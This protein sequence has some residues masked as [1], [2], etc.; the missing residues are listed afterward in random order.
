MSDETFDGR[1][2]QLD[3]RRRLLLQRLR[4]QRRQQP[5]TIGARPAGDERVPL[6]RA[7]EQLWFLAQLAPAEPTYNLV[8][9]SYLAGELD[10]GALR[11]ALDEVVRRHEALR[12]VVETADGEAYQRVLPPG[13]VTLATGDV[14]HLPPGERRA[15]TLALLQEKEVHR[16]FDLAAGPLFRARL[17]R[18]GPTEHALALA[19]HHIVVDGWSMGLVIRELGAAYDAYRRGGRPELP[20]PPLQYP[21]FA[22]WQRRHPAPADLE[23]HLR[24]W[25]DR[26][27][28]L[29][30]LELPTDRPRPATASFTGAMLDHPL[31]PQLHA[32][33]QALAK[34]AG[35][36][37]FMV[38]VA[39]FGALLARY[40]GADDLAVGT[41]FGGRSRPEL[42]GVVG[43][44]ANMGVLRLDASGDPSFATLVDRARD[45]CLG[46]W[47][48]QDAPFERVVQRLAPPRD[49]SRNPL[50]QVAVQL[51]D[52]STWGGPA[53]PGTDSDPVD[54]R[55]DRSRFDMMVSLIDHGDRYSVL[56]EYS[57]DLFEARRVRTMLDHLARLLDAGLADPGTRL[58]RLPLLDPA[59]RERVLAVGAGE[60][61]EV[62]AAT[63]L[64]LVRAQAERTPDL[65]AVRH[66]D[67]ELTYRELLDRAVRR[68][69]G[70]RAA[71]LR[72]G[73]R[74]P[75]LLDRGVDEVLSP[76]AIWHA[77]GVY[78]PLDTA[79][80]PNRLRRILTNCAARLLLT[81]VEHAAGVPDGPWRTLLLDSGDLDSG[82]LAP[83]VTAGADGPGPDDLAYVLHTSGTTGDPKGVQLPHRGF[84]TYLDW[85]RDLWRCGPGD[86]VLHGCAPVFDLAA[87]EVLAA[88]TSGATVVVI[89]KDRLLSP[90]GLAG[91]LEQERITH[92]FLTPTT[93][94]LAE[95]DTD[96]FGALREVLVGGEVCPADLV[97]RWARPGRRRF[98]NLYGPTEA[99][100]GCLAHD[101]TDWSASTPPPIG[102]SMPNRRTYVVDRWDNPVPPGVPGEILVGGAALSTGYLNDVGL[103]ARRFT[104]DP[105]VPDG[106]VYRTGDRGHWD[107][108]GRL[109]FDGRLDGQV[110]LRGLR[111]ELDEIEATLSRH[112]AV[113]RAAVTVVRDGNGVQRL[114][115]YV[116]DAAVPA[117][118]V[119]LRTHLAAELPAHLVP[120]HLVRLP[121]L[122]LTTSGK[123]NRRML[124]APEAGDVD[125]VGSA[126][127]GTTERQVAEI[128][129]EVLGVARVGAEAS[130]FD[131]GGHSL[132]A[133][134]VL[135]RVAGRLG[136]SVPLKQFYTTPTV[137][138]VARLAGHGPVA[139]AS[140]LVSLKPGG[141]RPRLYCP[142]AVSGSPYWYLPLSRALHPEQPMDG[143]EAPGLE[144]DADP[145][146]DLV[147]LAGRYVAALR[148]RQPHGPY[149][150]AGWSMGGFLCF[151]MARQLAA[152]GAAPD[153]VVM[154]D[155]NEPGP[156]PLPGERQV[157]ETFVADLAGLS[158]SPAPVLGAEVVGAPD[159]IGALT[160]FLV[161]HGLIPPDVRTD[162]VAH[163]YAVFR[164][165]MRA[166]YG[167]QP[168]RY[169]GRTVLV[170]AE[171]EASRAAWRRWAPELETLTLPGDHYSMWS[172]ANLPALASLIDTQVDRVLG[173][174]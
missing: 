106:R 90:D 72:P 13:P 39:A 38:L 14:S 56:T 81:R 18:L 33:V 160:A 122:P 145:I 103:T 68:A 41:T 166:I 21:D 163:R 142:H 144:G 28:D 2:A 146:D 50:F 12:T 137:R 9:A 62:A 168:A 117:D 71:G 120:G 43:F 55:L 47:E 136:A 17:V 114:V 73:D 121:A 149:L 126:P 140:P 98:V 112:P 53:L 59:E 95:G 172:P 34:E 6:S 4:E 159:P 165:N 74:V 80:P 129:A 162:F 11:R 130:F 135:S 127:T 101:C 65:V 128:F 157:M 132:Q 69:A 60:R 7:Q 30:T 15:A 173:V 156:L 82:D 26:L 78:V 116:V 124:P 119:A 174:G 139:D 94:G 63:V 42:E 105:F 133:A 22:R 148:E 64:Q 3:E 102:R 161:R 123:V 45:T 79:A 100:V 107:A 27:A 8:Q 49:P 170:Q 141:S 134:H 66:G 83:D 147:V 61:R 113:T 24:Y 97:A 51:L 44:F 36:S 164:A 92:L 75:V 104:G 40:T 67:D 125:E 32:G 171:R 153:L 29:P 54:L 91:V 110:K 37:P 76:L 169:P 131:L 138:A 108:D 85:M 77:G 19:V 86:R 151:E 155:S 115:G 93:L 143:F 31:D 48:H 16:P 96:R 52:G 111:V 99:T 167:Y 158:G 118:D 58:S 35:A 89:G 20:P 5:A 10:S 25:A 57:T 23:V 1:V 150:L 88:L 46:A 154:I 70:L 84:V 152:A 87:G 109:H